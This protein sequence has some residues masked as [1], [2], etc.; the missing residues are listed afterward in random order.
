MKSKSHWPLGRLGRWVNQY[1]M[2]AIAAWL[3][4]RMN[5]AVSCP[6]G[7]QVSGRSDLFLQHILVCASTAEGIRFDFVSASNLP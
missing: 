5:W 7:Q 6:R 1:M 2:M 4:L 3:P